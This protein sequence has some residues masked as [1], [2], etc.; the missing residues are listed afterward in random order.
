MAT[1]KERKRKREGHS[2]V[3]QSSTTHKYSPNYQKKKKKSFTLLWDGSFFP[4]TTQHLEEIMII[5]INHR[6]RTKQRIRISSR[7]FFTHGKRLKVERQ[8]KCKILREST[9]PV[10]KRAQYRSFNRISLFR[11]V[12]KKRRHWLETNNEWRPPCLTPFRNISLWKEKKKWTEKKEENEE[13]SAPHVSF[14]FFY[15]FRSFI[16][17][18][19]I[20]SLRQSFVETKLFKRKDSKR[21]LRRE[22]ENE[23]FEDTQKREKEDILW[24]RLLVN[25]SCTPFQQ[26]KQRWLQGILRKYTDTRIWMNTQ[27]ESISTRRRNH[28]DK[29]WTNVN[30][31]GQFFSTALIERQ[32]RKKEKRK[33]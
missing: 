19:F 27:E 21:E 8:R 31:F 25:N 12:K 32:K 13:S 16:D 33:D 30:F 10:R 4:E 1:K 9:T 3:S 22:K 18:W 15:T 6:F 20:F 2:E 28:R 24:L 5:G 29:T 14:F 26:E 7:Y 11:G 23:K 17:L